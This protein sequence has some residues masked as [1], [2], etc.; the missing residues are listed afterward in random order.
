MLVLHFCVCLLPLSPCTAFIR[1]MLIIASL[2][3]CPSRLREEAETGEGCLEVCQHPA[4]SHLSCHLRYAAMVSG[5]RPVE[6]KA[7]HS[8]LSHT[9]SFHYNQSSFEYNVDKQ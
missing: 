2:H 5:V 6:D 9:N 8:H 7:G 1:G 4:A 3:G